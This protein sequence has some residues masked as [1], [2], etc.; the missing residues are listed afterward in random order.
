MTESGFRITTA[1]AKVGYVV[2]AT[3]VEV[4]LA[5]LLWAIGLPDAAVPFLSAIGLVAMVVVGVRLFRGEDEPVEPPRAWWRMT[6]RPFAGFLLA[7]YFV[8]DALFARASTIGAF[9]VLGTV[10]MLLVAAAYV[11]S[12]VTLLLLRAQGRPPAGAFEA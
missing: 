5:L 1:Q 2:G 12:S 6:A 7:A 8:A 11:G 3:V 9:D 4:L 10:V